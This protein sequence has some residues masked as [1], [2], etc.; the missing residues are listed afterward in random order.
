MRVAAR[1][2]SLGDLI[3]RLGGELRGSRE[4]RI[5]QVA[6]LDSAGPEEL[7]FLGSDAY[8]AALQQS[9]A[10]AVVV[11]SDAGISGRTLIL[12]PNPYAYFIRAAELLN[13]DPEIVAGR[14]PM[15]VIH[16]EAEIAQSA[17]IGA[18]VSIERGARIGERV[19]LGPG[20]RVGVNAQ[21]GDDS[22]LHA[23]VTVYAHC[24]IGCRAVV[25]AGA[26]I[27][28]D[29]FG[30]VFDEGRWLKMPHLGR[31]VIGDDVEI[32]ANTTI[33]RG[34]MADTLIGDDVKLDNQI[35]IGHNVVI[36]AHTTIAGCSGIAGST[37]IGEHC[38]I[39]GAAIVTGHLKLTDRVVV[40]AGTV[41]M[42]SID[43]PGRYTGIYPSN[44]HRAWLR[45]A[46]GVKRLG[47]GGDV[48]RDRQRRHTNKEEDENGGNADR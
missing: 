40:S 44:E 15:A 28:A 22:W 39:G 18:F 16:P 32:G 35:Q 1:S 33:D 29:G 38:V 48:Q 3:D 43:R 6:P 30:G 17:E 37:R 46:V 45:S 7:S 4:T 20:C 13:P 14:H 25:N 5:A 26:V 12:A 36:G 23:N 21:I 31:V 42:R 10:G 9:R 24:Q 47:E 19:R 2:V 34:A 11:R 27:G 8:R 41:I